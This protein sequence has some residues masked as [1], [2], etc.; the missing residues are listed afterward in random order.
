MIDENLATF[1][2]SD[3]NGIGAAIFM[4]LVQKFGSAAAVLEAKLDEIMAAEIINIQL[5]K[6]IV[7]PKDWE[8]EKVKFEKSIVPGSIFIPFCH[9]SYPSKLKNIANPPPYLYIKGQ[10]DL[11]EGPALAI[12]GSR[13]PTDY[14]LR[15]AS[16]LSSELAAAGVVIIS[17]LAYGVDGAAHQAALE[18]GGKTIAVFGCGLNTIY[19]NGHKG[20][21]ERIT[22]SGCLISEFPK[23]TKPER[24]NFP[25]R[26]RVVAGLSDGVLV[27]EAGL[28]S[29][30]LVTASL[31]LDQG[32]DVLAVPGSV[33]SELSVGPNGLIKQGAIAVTAADDIF[34][35]FGWHKSVAA[36]EPAI[37]LNKLSRDEQVVFKELSIQ[38]VHIDEIGRKTNLGPGKTAEALLNLELKG[39][40]MR[41]PGNYVVRA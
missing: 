7:S 33:D 11:F 16:R 20:L 24:F 15:M 23:G 12:V 39:F 9:P 30:A 19:P 37:D 18:A 14:G 8:L 31:A 26:N 5:A 32:R 2:L 34:S 28:K 25:V 38:P 21:A 41:K 1:A 3:I 22:Q 13:R 6:K 35:N 27:I 36:R 17:G 4:Q 10:I 29:G 40:I